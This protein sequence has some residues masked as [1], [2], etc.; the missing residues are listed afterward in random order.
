MSAL[1]HL[2]AH[3]RVRSVHMQHATPGRSRISYIPR[4]DV[5]LVS[6]RDAPGDGDNGGGNDGSNAAPPS[7]EIAHPFW[8]RLVLPVAMVLSAVTQVGC[9][10]VIFGWWQ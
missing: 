3:K 10:G 6:L 2:L 9:I 8:W 5:P 1:Y 4:P 7:H